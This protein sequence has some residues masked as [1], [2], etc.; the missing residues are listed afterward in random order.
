MAQNRTLQGLIVKL[1][2]RF[3]PPTATTGD[4]I[5]PSPTTAQKAMTKVADGLQNLVANLGT[6][7]DKRYYNDY[8]APIVQDPNRLRAMWRGSWL[9]KNIVQIPADDMF[10]AWVSRSWDGSDADSKTREALEKNESDLQQRRKTWEAMIWGRLFGGSGI[11][12][13][14]KDDFRNWHKPLVLSEIKLGSLLG[15]QVFDRWRIAGGYRMDTDPS[16]PNCGNP[17][18]YTLA[19]S[20]IELHWTRVIRFNGDM[21]PYYDRAANGYWDDSVLQAPIDAVKDFDASTGGAASMI[22]EANVDIILADDLR[23]SIG[24]DQ[25]TANTTARWIQAFLMKSFNRTLL[26]DRQHEEYHQKT[27]QFSGVK[28]IMDKLMLNVA[29]AARIPVT[30]LFRQSPAGMDATGESDIKLYDDD[31]DGIRQRELVPNVRRMDEIRLMSL[32]GKIP[33]DFAVTANPLRQ[34][35]EAEQATVDKTRAD[36]WTTLKATGAI[37]SGLI[38]RE[39]DLLGTM[40]A[41]EDSDVQLAEEYEEPAPVIAA[42]P[43]GAVASDPEADLEGGDDI[44]QKE[45]AAK[46][47]AALD[48]RR[49]VGDAMHGDYI[50]CTEDG[51]HA[52]AGDKHIGGPYKTD[53]GAMGRLR[54]FSRS[55]RSPRARDRARGRSGRKTTRKAADAAEP[56]GAIELPA[57]R[58]SRQAE[59][60]YRRGLLEV[61][62]QLREESLAILSDLKPAEG[63]TVQAS[64]AR[65]RVNAA[66]SAFSDRDAARELAADVASMVLD[67]VDAKLDR[68]LTKAVRANL[69]TPSKGA[70]DSTMREAIEAN[71]DLI[72]SLPVQH[73]ERVAAALASGSDWSAIVTE[74][75]DAGRIAANRAELIAG[76]QVAKMT[77]AFNR[78][79]QTAVGIDSYRWAGKMDDRERPSHRALEGK[80]FRWDSPPMVDGD[81]VHPGEAIGCRCV[82][83]PLVA[84]RTLIEGVHQG[85]DHVVGLVLHPR[86]RGD[87]VEERRQPLRRRG[88]T[89]Q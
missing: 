37:T 60:F 3:L 85:V 17:L 32:F 8:A 10:R 64:A 27:N 84:Y 5:P 68:A 38:A 16:S 9:A 44:T 88:V 79:R 47:S 20:G 78:V 49:Y 48:A 63:D 4:Y 29:G 55:Y 89:G 35:T 76:D 80:V 43:G 71:V 53:R 28:D 66:V 33:E 19:D 21:L 83:V 18:F 65:A 87:L 40:T 13:M 72:A 30:K 24:T 26:L 58:P 39:M 74:V 15:W 12:P 56:G 34:M 61:V 14:F 52:Y 62:A 50:E 7:G 31:I 59:L 36:T 22:W 73:F 11:V 77:S 1:A 75:K 23:D 42:G 25:G 46:P 45:P 86:E 70:A 6:V 41:M 67:D 57:A 69:D 2:E 82:A 81:N 54:G 51:W